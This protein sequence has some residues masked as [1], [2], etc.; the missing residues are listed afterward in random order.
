MAQEVEWAARRQ[1]AK[2]TYEPVDDACVECHCSVTEGWGLGWPDARANA[3]LNEAFREEVCSANAARNGVG[4]PLLTEKVL[5]VLTTGRRIE[6]EGWSY[7][8]AG[9]A[10]K[11]QN[12]PEVLQM[13][14]KDDVDEHGRPRLAVDVMEDDEWG[15]DRK[16]VV[17]FH[18][19]YLSEGEHMFI[20]Y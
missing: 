20:N 4:D 8:Q 9:I 12:T 10:K 1:V 11:Y 3:A 14:L 6:R 18:E 7:T 13:E 17:L 16:K 2:N 15:E 19:K 5:T